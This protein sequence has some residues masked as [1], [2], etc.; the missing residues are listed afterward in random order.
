M[1]GRY[2]SNEALVDE[3]LNR[4]RE[5]GH[6]GNE[7]PADVMA[8]PFADRELLAVNLVQRLAPDELR[9]LA[10]KVYGVN[11]AILHEGDRRLQ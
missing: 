2:W 9:W 7:I 11:L 8:M 3:A 6:F 1:M 10:G 5:A 4:L